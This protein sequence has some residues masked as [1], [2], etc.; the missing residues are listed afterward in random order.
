MTQV[1]ANTDMDLK[2][3]VFWWIILYR[4]SLHG[5]ATEKGKKLMS[6]VI[7]NMANWKIKL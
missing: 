3:G 6:R 1:V 2:I 5:C 4:I 7:L